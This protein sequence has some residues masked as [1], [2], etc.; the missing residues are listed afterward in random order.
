MSLENLADA[1]R[2]IGEARAETLRGRV[3]DAVTREVPGARIVVSGR[4]VMITG[5]G[6]MPALRW[7]GSLIR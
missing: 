4:D 1:A 7:I 6:L 2:A 3:V 5:R